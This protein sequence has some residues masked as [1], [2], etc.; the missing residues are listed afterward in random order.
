MCARGG[1]RKGDANVESTEDAVFLGLSATLKHG[2][3]A[4]RHG[5]GGGG[6]GGPGIG[7]VVGELPAGAFRGLKNRRSTTFFVYR[8]ARRRLA[9]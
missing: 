4:T 1:T 7:T 9:V 2:R 8:Q 5:G 6:G 3:L